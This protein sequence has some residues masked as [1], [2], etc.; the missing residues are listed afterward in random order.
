[1]SE[2]KMG[3]MPE[4]KLLLTLS[5]PVMA[6]MLMSALYNIVDSMFVAR[7]SD[8]ALNA[9]SLCFPVQLLIDLCCNRHRRGAECAAQPGSRASSSSAQTRSQCMASCFL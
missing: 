7:I 5:L 4:G 9:V 3:S 8:D 6:S 2:N 1:M